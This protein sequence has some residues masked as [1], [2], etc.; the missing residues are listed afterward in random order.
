MLDQLQMIGRYFAL[1]PLAEGSQLPWMT[2][3]TD[4]VARGAVT[5]VMHNTNWGG[6][7]L[8]WL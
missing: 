8:P 1:V 3:V 7:E 2:L 5:Y 4:M 6:G